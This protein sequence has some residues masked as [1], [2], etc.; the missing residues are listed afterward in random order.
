MTY[1]VTLKTLPQRYVASVR[2]IIPAYDQEY[3]LWQIF[4]H[5]TADLNLQLA[6]PSYTLALFHD[7]GYKEHEVDIEIQ[8]AVK[9]TYADTEH[10]KFKTVPPIEIASATYKG[11][12]DQITAV[13][14]IVANWVNDNGYEFDGTSFCIY[15]VSPAE[16][17]DPNELVTEVCCPIRKK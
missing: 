17:Q 15:H 5:E 1:N 16:T 4:N 12:Y 9:G 14:L 7:E 10:V 11:S 3:L 2:Q 13:N 8:V 6:E